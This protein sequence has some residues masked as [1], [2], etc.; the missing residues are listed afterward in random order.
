LPT[1]FL[2]LSFWYQLPTTNMP[3][4]KKCNYLS[5]VSCHT[6]STGSH[7]LSQEA[8]PRQC[9]VCH[10]CHFLALNS[11]GLL[12]H[13]SVSPHCSW[14]WGPFISPTP[15]EPIDSSPP[16]DLDN[17]YMDKFINQ[18]CMADEDSTSV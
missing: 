13:L 17:D 2:P 18:N 3:V 4:G 14:M 6:T 7:P 9:C 5:S 11:T 8:E 1:L 10:I 12:Q 16:M 15:D